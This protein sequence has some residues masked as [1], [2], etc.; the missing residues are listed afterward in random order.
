[1]RWCFWWLA[2]RW[3]PLWFARPSCWFAGRS[4][5]LLYRLL[6]SEL[7]PPSLAPGGLYR[8]LASPGYLKTHPRLP[9]L[10]RPS[11][12]LPPRAPPG[13]VRALASVHGVRTSSPPRRSCWRPWQSLTCCAAAAARPSGSL[14]LPDWRERAL[15]P[16]LLLSPIIHW[17]GLWWP[18]P[19]LCH[20]LGLLINVLAP[21]P[22]TSVNAHPDPLLLPFHACSC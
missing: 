4:T 12:L 13:P 5:C 10:I 8:P 2:R 17:S 20:A 7:V 15:T 9:V 3:L 16:R 6:S 19:G 1:M 18:I 11:S 14:L 22:C 21:R